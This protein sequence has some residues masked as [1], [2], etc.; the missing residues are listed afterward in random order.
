MPSSMG[1]RKATRWFHST[2]SRVLISPFCKPMQSSKHQSTACSY[3]SKGAPA[4]PLKT[5]NQRMHIVVRESLLERLWKA[6]PSTSFPQSTGLKAQGNFT[7]LSHRMRHTMGSWTVMQSS[8]GNLSFFLLSCTCPHLSIEETWSLF[9]GKM[10]KQS[11]ASPLGTWWSSR[12]PCLSK[13]WMT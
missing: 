13:P 1:C 2:G 6:P 7:Y 12:F 10:M 9:L 5:M 4:S 3:S 8:P 11:A